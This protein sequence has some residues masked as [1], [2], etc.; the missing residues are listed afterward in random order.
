LGNL[1]DDR[2]R[3][4]EFAQRKVITREELVTLLRTTLSEVGLVLGSLAPNVL[5]ETRR[6]QG[7]E[8]EVL[9]AIFH[10]TEH[11]SMHTGQIILLTKMFSAGDLNFYDFDNGV[12][13]PRWRQKDAGS[14]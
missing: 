8:V 10:V 4:Q 2:N 12:P 11:F 6:I 9:E 14:A 13:S 7:K 5:L 3:D 1:P